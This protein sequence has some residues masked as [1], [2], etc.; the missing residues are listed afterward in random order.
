MSSRRKLIRS[1]VRQTFQKYYSGV[2]F[3][4]VVEWFEKGGYVKLPD[5]TSDAEA[6][7]NLS[8]VPGLVDQISVLG[9]DEDSGA[10]S[11][12]SAAEFI[13]EGL[14]GMKR[15]NRSQ[16]R[17]FY[18]SEKQRSEIGFEPADPA[19]SRLN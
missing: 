18:R 3:Q 5:T 10:A 2:D 15:I 11:V 6:L 13:L 14:A 19:K 8:K 7:G 17:G 16:E 1:A 12:V 4:S 9:L